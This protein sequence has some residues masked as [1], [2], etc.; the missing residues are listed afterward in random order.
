MPEEEEEEE[1]GYFN[2]TPMIATIDFLTQPYVFRHA[3]PV[4]DDGMI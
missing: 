4:R 1:E 3:S 2:I